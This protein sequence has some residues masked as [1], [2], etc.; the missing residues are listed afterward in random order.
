M[1]RLHRFL[2]DNQCYHVI[3]T[4]RDRAPLFRDAASARVVMDALQFVRR[5]RVYVLAYVVML[6]HM[7][8]LVVPKAGL[9]ISQV[10]Q[11]IKGYTARAINARNGKRG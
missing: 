4:T 9:T 7:H 3:T 6:E 5:E 2:L 8:A 1:A 10:M 11:T